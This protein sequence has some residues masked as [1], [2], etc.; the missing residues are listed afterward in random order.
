MALTYSET[1]FGFHGR[2]PR[3]LW[4]DSS[5]YVADSMNIGHVY[6]MQHRCSCV[7][8]LIQSADLSITFPCSPA[9]E[10]RSTLCKFL[11]MS[12]FLLKTASPDMSIRGKVGDVHG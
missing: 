2:N 7:L 6:G 3:T 10:I 8:L 5:S 4:L 9:Q 1:S 12:S 11:D